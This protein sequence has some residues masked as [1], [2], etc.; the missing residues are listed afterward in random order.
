MYKWRIT[1]P[2]PDRVMPH[3]VWGAYQSIF[4][5]AG[6]G[7]TSF[8]R[9]FSAGM[10]LVTHIEFTILHVKH[11]ALTHFILRYPRLE[12]TVTEL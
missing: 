12:F 2:A 4:S 8:N 9:I 11:S 7:V 5:D 3:A 1:V 6:F 10:V